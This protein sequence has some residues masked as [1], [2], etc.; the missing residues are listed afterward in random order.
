MKNKLRTSALVLLLAGLAVA[1]A[2]GL[3]ALGMKQ[4]MGMQAAVPGAPVAAADPGSSIAAG[5]EATRRHI[6]DGLKSR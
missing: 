4:G 6:K 3:Y 5:E 2:Y 1:A